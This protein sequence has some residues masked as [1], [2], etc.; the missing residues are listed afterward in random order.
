MLIFSVISR[1]RSRVITRFKRV[2]RFQIEVDGH[3][4]QVTME[5]AKM[6]LFFFL[7]YG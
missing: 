2:Y 7:V 6:L 4:M 5:I 3:S 1:L